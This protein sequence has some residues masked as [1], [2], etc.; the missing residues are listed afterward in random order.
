MW[1]VDDMI[2]YDMIVHESTHEAREVGVFCRCIFLLI[3]VASLEM[4]FRVYSKR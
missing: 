2:V 3:E 4:W 1:I